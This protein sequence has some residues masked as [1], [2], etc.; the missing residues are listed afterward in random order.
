MIIAYSKPFAVATS[1]QLIRLL[2]DTMAENQAQAV[3]ITRVYQPALP[4]KYI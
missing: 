3:I 1:N 2:P 4:I